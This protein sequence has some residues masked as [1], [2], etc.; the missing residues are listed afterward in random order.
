MAVKKKPSPKAKAG[1]R[2]ATVA[3]R[4][5]ATAKKPVARKAGGGK[6]AVKKASA[7]AAK[8]ARRRTGAKAVA[9]KSARP[10]SGDLRAAGSGNG[11][12]NGSSLGTKVGRRKGSHLTAKEI[13]QF[14]QLL[15]NLRD[16]VVD[17]ISFLAGD[18]LSGK[19]LSRTGEEGTDNFNREFAL[20][21]VSNEQDIIYEID[22]A[23]QRIH[24]GTY[25]ICEYSGE[26]IEKERL[27]IL[28]HAR[29]CVRVQS[30]LERGRARYRPFG[31]SI[32]RA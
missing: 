13:K 1:A 18:N 32:D 5:T 23:I 3:K 30:E 22:E 9:A 26:P 31:P 27:K 8:P 20:K 14:H 19:T 12:G 11:S 10:R 25:G 16:Q 28:P 21:L 4:S 7:G 17:E 29:H 15:L 2:K 6:S 24:N